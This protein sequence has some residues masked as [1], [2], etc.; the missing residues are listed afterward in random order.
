MK[1]FAIATLGCKV[2]QYD[3]DDV[4][5]QLKGYGE[6]DFSDRADLYIVNTCGVTAEAEAKARQLLRRAKRNNPGAFLVLTGCFRPEDRDQLRSLGVDLF[7]PNAQKARRAELLDDEH[8]REGADETL[9]S[10]KRTR[11]FIKVQDGCDQHCS[12]CAIPSFRGALSSRPLDE[13]VEEVRALGAAGVPEVV[14]T[15]IHLGKY[16]VDLDE[17]ADLAGLVAALL[18]KTT[19]PRFRLS[20][21]EPQEVTG[22]LIELMASERRLA[23]HLH[24]PLQSGNDR[25]L[26]QMNRPYDSAGFKATVSRI[27]QAVPGIGLTTDVMVGFPGETEAEFVE[28]LTLLESGGLSRLHVFKFSARPGTPAATMPGAVSEAVKS[29][30]ASRARELGQILLRDYCAGFVDRIVETVPEPPRDGAQTGLTGEYLRVKFNQALAP[31]G[32]I[33]QVRVEKSEDGF[34]LGRVQDG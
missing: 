32:R 6:V 29:A 17:P 28:T 24:L 25:I 19:V 1:T 21:L 3:G 26:A 10:T 16:G 31:I 4:R 12:Y 27:D 5:R 18:Q 15:G 14:L 22:D 8:A 34:L 33:C 30:R 20:S 13:V 2:N 7:V 23:P 9:G 11:V